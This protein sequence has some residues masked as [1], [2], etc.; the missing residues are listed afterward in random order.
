MPEID[1][2]L[3]TRRALA[4]NPYLI[5]GPAEFSWPR[6]YP[7]QN[8]SKHDWPGLIKSSKAEG[9]DE[10]VGPLVD[11]LQ[12]LQNSD[13]DLDAF[14]RLRHAHTHLPFSWTF[15][16]WMKSIVLEIDSRYQLVYLS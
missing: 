3:K 11:V 1:F 6:G 5:Y 9:G 7:I 16:G 2:R 4:I 15:K 8:I 13:P 14:W 12:V 10:G